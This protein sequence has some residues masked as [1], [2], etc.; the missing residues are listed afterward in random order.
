MDEFT[1]D[2]ISPFNQP[3][4]E[5]EDITGFKFHIFDKDHVSITSSMMLSPQWDV[6]EK[7]IYLRKIKFVYV[8]TI[9]I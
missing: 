5:N 1:F 4:Y 8:F 3:F 7:F 9:A 6:M 2:I